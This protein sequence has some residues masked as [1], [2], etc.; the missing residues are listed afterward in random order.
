MKPLYIKFSDERNKKYS[1][2][3][4]IMKEAGQFQVVKEPIFAEGE[5][6]MDNIVRY[7]QIL[8]E[9]YRN[10]EICPV[11]KEQGKLI[12]AFEDGK[13]LLDSYRECMEKKDA[14]KY[15]KLL[16]YH[17]KC[18]LGSETNKCTFHSTPQAEKMFGNLDFLEGTAGI[19]AANFDATASNIIIK[20]EK[21]VFID[22]E[23]VMEFPIPEELAIYHCIRDTYFHLSGLEQF[24]SLEQAVRDLGITAEISR[25]EDAYVTFFQRVIREEDGKSF[26]EKKITCLKKKR[27]IKEYIEDNSYAHTEW[28]K[29][30]DNWKESAKETDRLTEENKT[31]RK[32]WEMCADSWKESVK[33][34]ERL[35]EENKTIRTEWKKCA[36]SWKESVKEIERLTEENKGIRKEWEIC[37]DNWKESVK[38]IERLTEENKAIRAEWEKCAESW[39]ESCEENKRLSTE[40]EGHAKMKEEYEELERKYN[41]IINSRSWKMISKMHGA[42]K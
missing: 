1:I 22:Y 9:S 37:A 21:P 10:V 27:S 26:A 41:E 32:E 42:K 14:E 40:L 19:K 3:T 18:I 5:E 2:K 25:L 33:E 29:C 24:F 15:R 38:E 17:K 36:D 20:D 7:A 28:E 13:S 16:E 35:T 4:T 6:H 31:I 8:K 11:R 12:F 34:I 23:W 39:K 30:A